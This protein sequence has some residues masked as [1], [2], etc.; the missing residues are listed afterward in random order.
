MSIF[1]IST[2][3]DIFIFEASSD[4]TSSA[5]WPLSCSNAKVCLHRQNLCDSVMEKAVGCRHA[6]NADK[7]RHVL[8]LSSIDFLPV[9]A[10]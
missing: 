8:S 3:C 7:R 5:F 4:N 1:A 6:V 2:I 9:K 10:F